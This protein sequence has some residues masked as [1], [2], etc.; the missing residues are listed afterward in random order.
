M[1]AKAAG[2]TSLG[3]LRQSFARAGRAR[4]FNLSTRTLPQKMNPQHV[5]QFLRPSSH[6]PA[7]DVRLDQC[8][9]L[10]PR[11]HLLHF[12][13]IAGRVFFVYRSNPV[14]IA[15]VLCLSRV[16]KRA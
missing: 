2:Y 5:L 4:W 8:A 13:N 15:S 16:V 7:W 3:H 12:H 9:Q 11:H 14:I 10:C 6:C 1:V